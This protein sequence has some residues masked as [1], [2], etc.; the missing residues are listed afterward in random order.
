MVKLLT[1]FQLK[2]YVDVDVKFK[3]ETSDMTT[4]PSF[5]NER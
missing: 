3:E 1:V 4:S 2:L 5:I